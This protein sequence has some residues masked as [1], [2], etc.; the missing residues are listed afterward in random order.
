VNASL[1]STTN[2]TICNNQ[3]PYSWNG[4]T[5]NAAGTYNV[6]L[7]AVSGCDSVATL[8]LSL[9]ANPNLIV[10]DPPPVCEPASIN[11]TNSSLINGSDP[12]LG[13]TFWTDAAASVPLI[14][15][16]AVN[17][18]GT[19]Y[20]KGSNGAGCISLQPVS[21]VIENKITGIRY[22]DLSVLPNTS[23]DLQSRNPGINYT[24]QW[25]PQSGLNFYDISNPVFNDNKQTEYLIAITSPAG[26]I[27]VDTLLVKINATFQPN[28]ADIFVPKAWS[29]NGDGHNDRLFPFLV[30]IS[31]V[32]YFRIFNRW[33]QLVFETNIPG[34]GWNGLFNG[35]Q[36]PIDVYTWSIEAVTTQGD[37][38]KKSGNSVLL[39]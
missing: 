10:S 4:Q 8:V 32:K 20:I 27:T 9:S 17:L 28:A 16:A 38:I 19:Y 36:Q 35:N 1:T 30:N 21:V 15:P 26:C 39:R 23:L 22:P 18:T 3:L 12:G 7:T 14:N 31:T 2:T 24:Y 11:L 13:Y 33:G 29:P 25:S 37:V 5:Y 6:T 34:N